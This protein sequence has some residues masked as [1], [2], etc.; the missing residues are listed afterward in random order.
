MN[1]NLSANIGCKL[2]EEFIFIV[3]QRFCEDLIRDTCSNIYNNKYSDDGIRK[4]NNNH[5]LTKINVLD[6]FN[7]ICKNDKY[8][9]LANNYMANIKN[10]NNSNY[11][12]TKIK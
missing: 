5:Y 8:D 1:N 12:V 3:S 7:T 9:F 10:E 11:E 2:V 6:V 4:T